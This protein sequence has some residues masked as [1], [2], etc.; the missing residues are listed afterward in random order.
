MSKRGTEITN[1]FLSGKLIIEQELKKH[2]N[3]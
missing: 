1:F 3:P 2:L